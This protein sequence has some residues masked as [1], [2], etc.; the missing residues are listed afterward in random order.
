MSMCTTASLTTSS[1]YTS[2][3]LRYDL[4]I[5]HVLTVHQVVGSWA[6]CIG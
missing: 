5:V 4:V 2:S 6:G 3:I 1:H